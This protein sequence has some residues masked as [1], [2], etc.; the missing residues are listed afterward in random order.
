MIKELPNQLILLFNKAFDISKALKHLYK[1]DRYYIKLL[2]YNLYY[3]FVSSLSDICNFN[4]F[5]IIITIENQFLNITY[6]II[7]SDL[8]RILIYNLIFNI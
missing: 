6:F 2:C 5:K 1:Q 4:Y 7:F 8:Q 3:L